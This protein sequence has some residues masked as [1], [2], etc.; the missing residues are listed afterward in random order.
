MFVGI[1]GGEEVAR[2]GPSLNILISCAAQVNDG[3]CTGYIGPV[4]SRSYVKMI[5]NGIKYGDMQL[6]AEVYDIMSNILG[7][8]NEEMAEVFTEW[9]KANL[10]RIWL[11]LLPSFLLRRATLM[12]RAM[13]STMCWIRPARKERGQSK[14]LLNKVLQQQPS[15]RHLMHVS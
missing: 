4:G 14:R 7:M 9:K 12:Q 3:P 15:L 11:K 1:S 10:N 2:N 6:I 13:L 8:S 5:H